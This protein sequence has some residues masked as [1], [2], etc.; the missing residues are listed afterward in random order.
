LSRCADAPGRARCWREGKRRRSRWTARPAT[1]TRCSS[2]RRTREPPPRAPSRCTSAPPLRL[3]VT[4]G[5]FSALP[6]LPTTAATLSPL[7][8]TPYN[9][10]Y[11]AWPTVI[12]PV[13]RTS[14]RPSGR[15]LCWSVESGWMKKDDG[16]EATE[17]GKRQQR[18]SSASLPT[19]IC[20]T[21]HFLSVSE[22]RDILY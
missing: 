14:L 17:T 2:T 15:T 21:P 11:L 5:P 16:A 10:I 1:G 6:P 18:N 4:C 13:G 7:H 8:Y 19:F 3:V 22:S 20:S 9:G 12:R